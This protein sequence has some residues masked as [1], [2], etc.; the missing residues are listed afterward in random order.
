MISETSGSDLIRNSQKRVVEI[1]QLR[2]PSS[3]WVQIQALPLTDC[4]TKPYFSQLENRDSSSYNLKIAVLCDFQ[5]NANQ[6][7]STSLHM[8]R[9]Q[10]ILTTIHFMALLFGASKCPE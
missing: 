8:I 1:F 6:M 10:Q 7:L 5:D 4:M 3:C 9:S 2:D